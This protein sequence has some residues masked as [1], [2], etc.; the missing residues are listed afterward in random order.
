MEGISEGFQRCLS[1]CPAVIVPA[2][3]RSYAGVLAR[4][5]NIGVLP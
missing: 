4:I 3:A 2:G 1:N 5:M